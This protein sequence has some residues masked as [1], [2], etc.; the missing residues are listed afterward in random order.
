MGGY[1]LGNNINRL[2]GPV[3]I[4]LLILAGLAIIAG[5]IFLRRNEKRLEEEAEQAMPGPLDAYQSN[6]IQSTTNK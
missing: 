1:F 5:L 4:T 3:G 2:T 6:K